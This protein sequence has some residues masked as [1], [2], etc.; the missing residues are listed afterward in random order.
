MLL[1]PDCFLWHLGRLCKICGLRSIFLKCLRCE[2]P[3]ALVGHSIFLRGMFDAR[4]SG[5]VLWD[6]SGCGDS[7]GNHSALEE[8][9]RQSSYFRFLCVHQKNTNHEY[10]YSCMRSLLTTNHSF[11]PFLS[12]TSFGPSFVS[13][14]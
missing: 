12:F 3:L 9:S 13:T 14:R 5:C 4:R 2:L 8:F 1:E 7:C 11:S 10:R 6:W